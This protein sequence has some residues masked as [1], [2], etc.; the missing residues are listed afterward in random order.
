[1]KRIETA[2]LME[3]VGTTTDV[4]RLWLFK[5]WRMGVLMSKGAYLL[6][7]RRR[8][9]VRLGEATFEK[10]KTGDLA[11]KDLEPLVHKLEKLTKKVELEEMLIRN[12]RYGGRERRREEPP[13]KNV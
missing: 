6:A 10:M 3:K 11:A 7:E 1:L 13:T 5:A 8:L 4:L 9:F 2:A 12:L